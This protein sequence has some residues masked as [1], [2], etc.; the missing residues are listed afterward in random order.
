MPR[1]YSNHQFSGNRRGGGVK[2]TVSKISIDLS[3]KN[4]TLFL[5]KSELYI[6]VYYFKTDY[7]QFR[8][9]SKSDLRISTAGKIL[10]LPELTL[11]NQEK[12][13]YISF[14]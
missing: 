8:F 2:G 10:D 6:N 7:V 9:L 4:E 12:R 5:I 11:F 3:C 1:G 14:Y 13:Q